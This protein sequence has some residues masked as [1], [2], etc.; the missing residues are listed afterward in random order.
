[1]HDYWTT[2]THLF[3]FKLF[4]DRSIEEPNSK[5]MFKKLYKDGKQKKSPVQRKVGFPQW[6]TQTTH[7][8]C[9]LETE[10]VQWTDAVKIVIWMYVFQPEKEDKKDNEEKWV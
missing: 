2:V 1:M 4:I 10:S 5:N 7:G 9:N 6:H 3:Y 8:H